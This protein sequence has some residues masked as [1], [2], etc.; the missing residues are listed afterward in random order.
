MV[1]CSI[2]DEDCVYAAV[3]GPEEAFNYAG[4][5]DIGQANERPVDTPRVH[6]VGNVLFL[7]ARRRHGTGR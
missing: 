1:L 4:S 2:P 3:A 5:A 7:A 6:V